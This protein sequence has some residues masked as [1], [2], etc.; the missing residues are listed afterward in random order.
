MTLKLGLSLTLNPT[1][2]RRGPL[3]PC[4][5]CVDCR[6]SGMQESSMVFKV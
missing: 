6:A 2:G 4:A 1:S 5:G 3:D